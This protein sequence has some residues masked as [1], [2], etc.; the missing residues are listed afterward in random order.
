[1]HKYERTVRHALVIHSACNA[2]SAVAFSSST[3][4]LFAFNG[5]LLD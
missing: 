2:V 3:R 1:V 5:G 4:P